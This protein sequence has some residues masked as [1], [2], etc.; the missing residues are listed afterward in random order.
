MSNIIDGYSSEDKARVGKRSRQKCGRKRKSTS[1]TNMLPQQIAKYAGGPLDEIDSLAYPQ[2]SSME[3]G[4]GH[5]PDVRKTL[6][7]SMRAHHDLYRELAGEGL[8]DGQ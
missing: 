6:E 8:P 3:P 2:E 7:E 1:L 4:K 5:A